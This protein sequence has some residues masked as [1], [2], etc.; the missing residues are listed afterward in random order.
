MHDADKGGD[1]PKP[2]DNKPNPIPSFG[3]RPDGPLVTIVVGALGSGLWA[4]GSEAV[5]VLLTAVSQFERHQ[6][7]R[8]QPHSSLVS[9]ETGD[10]LI[11]T[12][13]SRVLDVSRVCT[14]GVELL[15]HA[16]AFEAHTG[17]VR[18]NEVDLVKILFAFLVSDGGGEEI[19]ALHKSLLESFASAFK[20]ELYSSLALKE[21]LKSLPRRM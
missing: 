5:R 7:G 3:S 12:G 20:A 18:E 21:H 6:G 17:F 9:C 13:R 2:A 19:A 8:W 16:D 14:L 10:S 15:W 1:A 4:V 11:L